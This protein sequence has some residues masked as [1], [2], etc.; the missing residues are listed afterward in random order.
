MVIPPGDAESDPRN[1][2]RGADQW[3]FV[4]EGRG[5]ARVKSRRYKPVVI[6]N[7]GRS[8]GQA[9]MN[10]GRPTRS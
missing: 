5:S 4:V 7:L 6:R 9:L 3:L 2:H 10:A 1:R 8:Q